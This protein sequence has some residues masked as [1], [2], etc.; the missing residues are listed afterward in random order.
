MPA[1]EVNFHYLGSR[2]TLES[3]LIMAFR[4]AKE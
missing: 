2:A 4:A 3:T 1:I